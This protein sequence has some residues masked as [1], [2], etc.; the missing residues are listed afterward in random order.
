MDTNGAKLTIS[1]LFFNFF[2]LHFI[3]EVFLISQHFI[4][5]NLCVA[6]EYM[7]SKVKENTF[8]FILKLRMSSKVFTVWIV[9]VGAFVFFFSLALW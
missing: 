5:G 3:L 6:L 9:T 4:E 7:L 8:K 2:F 1:F